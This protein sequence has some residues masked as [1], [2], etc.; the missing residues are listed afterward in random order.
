MQDRII[1][2][3]R[4]LPGSGKSTMASGLGGLVFSTDD[5]FM[6]DGQYR[7]DPE[8]IAEYH[9]K[10]IDRT[11]VAMKTGEPL[12]VIDNTNILAAHMRPYVL[13]ADQYGYRVEIRMP[14]TPWMWDVDILA[15]RNSHHVSRDILLRM[16][17][18]FEQPIDLQS[19]RST[20]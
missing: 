13:L 19:I 3:M 16:K 2:L 9:Q 17:N 11:E 4:G 10:N 18:A 14:T 7:F 8:K 6:V 5:F 15:E 12:I 20:H 1:Y